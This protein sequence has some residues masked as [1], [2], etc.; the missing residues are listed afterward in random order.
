VG[1]ASVFYEGKPIIPNAG[2]LWEMCEKYK[3][4]TLVVAPTA[5]RVIKKM[6][7]DG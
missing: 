2:K 3:S 6:D 4:K 7:F 5:L 1:A